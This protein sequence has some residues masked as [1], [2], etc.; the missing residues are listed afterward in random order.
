M[1]DHIVKVRTASIVAANRLN[2]HLILV[3]RSKKHEN[4]FVLPGGKVEFNLDGTVEDD[5]ECAKR[6]LEEETGLSIND[7]EW[8]G[9]ATD[10]N[11]DVR[12]VPYSKIFK[13][14]TEPSLTALGLDPDVLIEAHYGVPDA[15]YLGYYDLYEVE[16]ENLELTERV[17][18]NVYDVKPDLFGAGHDV[19]VLWYRWLLQTG[20]QALP[21]DALRDFSADRR[22]LMTHFSRSR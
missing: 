11:R 16:D 20:A 9:K 10:H 15:I 18:F 8:I 12:T 22:S 19:I 6:E 4:R 7:V 14:Y 13:A 1:S 3:G 17:E 2:P 5:C 21:S